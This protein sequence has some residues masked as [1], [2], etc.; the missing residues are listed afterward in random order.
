MLDLTVSL[1]CT[2]IPT[3]PVLPSVLTLVVIATA[4]PNIESAVLFRAA[5]SANHAVALRVALD[6][7]NAANGNTERD[8]A[9][10]LLVRGRVGSE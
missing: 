7:L 6:I 8:L 3:F 9:L 10:R 4:S 5:C 1:A 2:C